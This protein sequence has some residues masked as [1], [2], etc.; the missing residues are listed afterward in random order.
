[1]DQ[2]NLGN[3]EISSV[4]KL[5]KL[6]KYHEALQGLKLLNKKFNHF[7]INWY[8]GHVYFKLHNYSEAEN[9]VSFITPVPGGVGPMT[10]ACLLRNTLI[11]FKNKNS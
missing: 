2:I 4:T 1:M 5:I 11:A 7:L 8:L 3:K 9:K 6:G 10:I